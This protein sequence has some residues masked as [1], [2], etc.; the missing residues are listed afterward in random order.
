MSSLWLNASSDEEEVPQQVS[1]KMDTVSGAAVACALSP[2]PKTAVPPQAAEGPG[3][4]SDLALQ[5]PP[6]KLMSRSLFKD[7][8]PEDTET[9]PP[10]S[11]KLRQ[12]AAE[13]AAKSA[14]KA[15]SKPKAKAAARGAAGEDSSGGRGKDKQ[16]RAV[17]GTANTFAGN[18]PPKD[19][20]LREQFMAIRD[21]YFKEVEED[22]NGKRKRSKSMNQD[23]FLKSMRGH[24]SA[25]TREVCGQVGLGLTRVVKPLAQS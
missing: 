5:T 19:P 11:P 1:P 12:M 15:K 18:R 3:L 7:V 16:A 17:R 6:S 4:A 20:V 25:D 22:A 24:I 21:A 2:G 9:P 8:E 13:A 23:S 10:V 14:A